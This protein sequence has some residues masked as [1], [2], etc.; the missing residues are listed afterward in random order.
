V[1]SL[2]KLFIS[3]GVAVASVATSTAFSATACP[4]RISDATSY[5][6]LSEA[7]LLVR[8]SQGARG[9]SLIAGTNASSSVAV[10]LNVQQR[11]GHLDL[12]ASGVFD[13]VEAVAVSRKLL[14]F[15]G[16]PTLPDG[17]VSGA[18][19]NISMYLNSGNPTIASFIES[20]FPMMTVVGTK[21]T[22]GLPERITGAVLGDPYGDPA[23]LSHI[24]FLESGQLDR[25]VDPSDGTL[26]IAYFNDGTAQVTWAD[27]V[28]GEEFE[29]DVSGIPLAR[30]RSATEGGS[31][32]AA[33]NPV[34]RAI[35]PTA[36]REQITVTC[37]TAGSA[38]WPVPDAS[39]LLIRRFAS[40][41]PGLPMSYDVLETESVSP[42]VFRY[43]TPLLGVQTSIAEYQ[44]LVLRV[45]DEVCTANGP[46]QSQKERIADEI[47]RKVPA[48]KSA[49][50]R[51]KVLS[52]LAK[53]GRVCLANNAW[54]IAKA[55]EADA[56][57][58]QATIVATAFRRGFESKTQEWTLYG[59]SPT[60][61]DRT[62]QLPAS[63]CPT[64][65]LS[66]DWRGKFT[67]PA[68]RTYN[69]E[70]EMSLTFAGRVATGTSRVTVAG[71]PT[72]FGNFTLT[73]TVTGSEFTFSETSI[74]A[75]N[76]LP[77]RTW[78]IKSGVLTY[79]LV[80]G[81]RTLRGPWTAPGCSPGEVRLASPVR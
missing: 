20:G 33:S 18:V 32:A 27:P 78:C 40:P 70:N 21:G 50:T 58:N 5:N 17:C 39:L 80:N 69:Y 60:P 24:T 36:W 28:A 62:I 43:T 67:Q 26:A 77:G 42:G 7:L 29:V 79:R 47:S 8:F 46:V 22:A 66:G 14:G 23:L 10:E 3:L 72:Y 34:V 37:Q 6:A 63:S 76:P 55:F 53:V 56:A 81:E 25:V 45:V 19:P 13:L 15:S 41:G 44:P 54:E 52:L 75:Q 12:D 31:V 65:N 48:A 61:V 68:E 2:H 71:D 57:N 16:G 11:L 64:P 35:P 4:W 73:G 49:A 74:T 30:A 9:N 59:S 51:L 38:A 1:V